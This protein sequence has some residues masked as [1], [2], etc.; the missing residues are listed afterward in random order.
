MADN[1][2]QPQG[3]LHYVFCRLIDMKITIID[4]VRDHFHHFRLIWSFYCTNI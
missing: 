2:N 1:L 3:R 4:E